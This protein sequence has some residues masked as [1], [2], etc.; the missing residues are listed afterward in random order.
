MTI[1]EEVLKAKHINEIIDLTDYTTDCRRLVKLIHPDVCKEPNAAEAFKKFQELKRTY[2]EGFKFLDDNGEVVIKD[3]LIRLKGD[4]TIIQNSN[5]FG[6]ELI[7]YGT[8]N[9]RKYLPISFKDTEITTNYNYL[10]LLGV[11]LPE[12]HVRWILNRLLEFCAYM[13]R[14]GLVHGGLTVES[15]LIEPNSHGLNVITFYHTTPIGAK[16]KTVSAK[17]KR[18]YPAKTFVDKKATTAIDIALVKGMACT[19]L[20]DSSGRGVKLK[21]KVSKPLMNFILSTHDNAY[22]AMNDYKEMLKANYESK[23]YQLKL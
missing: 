23:F 13:E 20:G 8:E 10:T 17:Y 12:E 11:T 21:G 9:F 5:R 15:A 18:F 19:L 3:T 22:V 14:N 2:E 4:I 7:K 6:N 1:I 16:L